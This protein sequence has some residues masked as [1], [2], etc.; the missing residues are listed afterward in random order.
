MLR[1]GIIGMGV[2]EQHIRGFQSAD[3]QL[4]AIAEKNLLKHKYLKSKYP[5]ALIFDNAYKMIRETQLDIVSI[6]SFDQDHAEQIIE[7]LNSGCHVFCE[8]PL[9]LTREDLKSI[10]K[11]W[12]KSKGLRI[13]SNTI[14][15]MSPLFSNIKDQINDGV[16]GDLYQL[17]GDYNYGRIEKLL[18]GWRGKIPDYSV[19]LGG[20]IHMIDIMRWMANCEVIEVVAYGNNFFSQTSQHVK[21]DNVT[22]LLKF[23][24]GAIGKISANFGCVH[25]HFH[26]LAIYG[27]KATFLHSVNGV[28]LIRDRSKY[29]KPIKPKL[30]YLG[31][32]KD[33]LIPNFVES[34]RGNE[35]LI[36]KEKDVFSSIA[37]CLSIDDSVKT[38][39][40]VKVQ[41]FERECR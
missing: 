3:T 17:E 1:V 21:Q 7:S 38:G 36:V 32:S 26:N 39:L 4:V 18:S 35:L 30:S 29:Y 31:M 6:A 12:K 20:G 15:R 11:M 10:I 5:N 24:S 19:M 23:S 25:P 41:N 13:S 14:L 37:I 22:A 34:I 8:K 28:S 33:A 9:C 16:F 2:G 27:T 40:P